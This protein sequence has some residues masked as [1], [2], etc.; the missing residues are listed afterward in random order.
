MMVAALLAALLALAPLPASAEAGHSCYFFVV[1]QSGCKPSP[2]G[3]AALAACLSCA[4][5]A[6]PKEPHGYQH[7][8]QPLIDQAC[9][10]VLPPAPGPAPPK[11]GDLALTLLPDAAKA[12]GAVCLDG[13]PAGYYF[14]EGVGAGK[15][16]WLL[17]FNGGGWCVGHDGSA[18]AA[19]K[20]C[21]ARA[22]GA[23]GS[24]KPWT[25]TRPADAHGMTSPDCAVNPAFCTWTVAYM[26]CASPPRACARLTPLRLSFV[27]C[28]D[29]DGTSFSGD[30]EAPVVVPGAKVS[31]IFFRGKRILDANIAHLLAKRSLGA[32]SRVVLS[33][34][35]AGGLATFLH[36]DYVR[37]LLPSTLKSYAAVP[38][39]GFFLDHTDTTGQHSFGE[40]M[41]ATFTLANSSAVLNKRCLGQA[42]A[43]M[44]CI[45]PQHFAQHIATPLF[46]TQSQYDAWQLPNI[47][48]LGCDPPHKGNCSQKQLS[49]FQQY[50]LDT[51]AALNASGLFQPRSG[52][53][54]WNDACIAHTQGYYGDYCELCWCFDL[55]SCRLANLDTI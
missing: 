1:H 19:A 13:S 24:S 10:G 9:H 53:G 22:E 17:V 3:G 21:S 35:S 39:A 38:D 12:R 8:T 14:R 28:A 36:A 25:K 54:I 51:M 11:A 34:H 49:S 52:H 45:F 6:L 32:A 18:A 55:R 23:L 33:G 46:V 5:R 40:G 30:R 20:G 4:A 15:D 42:S 31:P 16:K 41:R 48:K 26:F 27:A 7:C 29:C 44:D 2:G 43:A 47:L 37:T 50:R